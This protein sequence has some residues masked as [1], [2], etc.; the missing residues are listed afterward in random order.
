MLVGPPLEWQFF[1]K[2][3][4]RE[5]DFLV[6]YTA[7]SLVRSN[8]SPHI[9]DDADTGVD[10][11]LRSASENT[12]LATAARARGIDKVMLYVYPPTLADLLVPLSFLPAPAAVIAWTLVNLIALLCVAF[13]LAR[14]IGIHFI[15]TGGLAVAAFCLGF[16]RPYG[17]FAQG[18]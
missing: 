8:L 14:M 9:Y 16:V 18:R 12:C 13:L 7:A 4:Q 6:Y 10:P 2:A 5:L 15:S 1:I 11:Q 3:R 17:V